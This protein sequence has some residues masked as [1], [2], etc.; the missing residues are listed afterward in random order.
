MENVRSI[1]ETA[2]FIYGI[3][4]AIYI[5]LENRRPQATLAWMLVFI[6]LPVL[7]VVIYILFGRT[8]KA[9]SRQ[10]ELLKQ[11]LE[12][13]K[14]P[15]LEKIRARQDAESAE[16]EAEHPAAGRIM[17]L[18]RRNSPSALRRRNRVEI[19]QNA[20]SFYP[21]MMDDLKAAR[22]SIHL[23]YFIWSADEVGEQLKDILAERAKAGVAVRLLYDP[24]G[25]RAHLTKAYLRELAAAG[26]Q[27]APTTPLYQLHT[28][29]Y[30]NHRKITLIDGAVGYIGG[31]NIGLEHLTGGEG[32]TFWRDTQVR[33]EGEAAT[34]LQTVFM[35]DWY[36]AVREDLFA[37]DYFPAEAIAPVQGDV[38]LQIVTSG[39]DSRW[40]AIRQLYFALI[41]TAQ[42]HVWLQS[43][44][45]ILDATVAEALT[46]AA[47]AGVDVKV[48]LSARPSGNPVPDWAGNTFIRDV[49]QAGVRVY[50]YR[51]GY[52]HAK[53]ISIDGELCSIGSANID[54][55]SF[56]INYEINAVLYSRDLA[57]RLEQDFER[58]LADCTL[59]DPE[60]YRRRS[61]LLRA[62]DSFA[63]LLSPLL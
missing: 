30:R 26:I 6:F 31:M 8:P 16:I 32:F 1:L 60:E 48:M 45:F 38:P 62:R 41:V 22:R 63:R 46:A 5:V 23:Q 2:F 15:V 20:S 39:P 17:T 55:R 61:I 37:L 18:I 56:S 35:V 12:A 14:N 49:I 59:F 58:D 53:T 10:G 50:Q 27:V 52:L 21:R 43:P 44:F 4:A 11:H 7:G 54:I 40:A 42:R 57:R 13:D 33:L 36:N 29:S 9:F 19:L 47:L 3:A 24:I 34:L 28:I 25:S 51:K